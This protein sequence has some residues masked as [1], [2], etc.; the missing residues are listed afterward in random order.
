MLTGE[1]VASSCVIL[2]H[3]DEGCDPQGALKFTLL[4]G[5]AGKMLASGTMIQ[6]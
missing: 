4:D 1:P 5:D 6:G 2:T 3:A